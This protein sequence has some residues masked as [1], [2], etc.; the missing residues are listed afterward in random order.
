[1]GCGELRGGQ[2]VG[3][4]GQGAEDRCLAGLKLKKSTECAF[5]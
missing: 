1:V 4:E 2:G 3:L 5:N